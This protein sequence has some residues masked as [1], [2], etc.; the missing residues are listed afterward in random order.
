MNR[1]WL[2]FWFFSV[3]FLR[4]QSLVG[5]RQLPWSAN[6]VTSNVIGADDHAAWSSTELNKRLACLRIGMLHNPDRWHA[7]RKLSRIV[8]DQNRPSVARPCVALRARD[9]CSGSLPRKPVQRGQP[10]PEKNTPDAPAPPLRLETPGSRKEMIVAFSAR[11]Y[12]DVNK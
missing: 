2:A 3:V 5:Q 4:L 11:W 8:H 12:A 9:Q 10:S 1:S 6:P 7:A